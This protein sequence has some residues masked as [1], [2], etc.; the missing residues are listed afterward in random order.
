MLDHKPIKS[1]TLR[2]SYHRP[3]APSSFWGG[4]AVICPLGAADGRVVWKGKQHNLELVPGERP[5]Q[6]LPPDALGSRISMEQRSQGGGRQRS[7]NT[8][9]ANKASGSSW[10]MTGTGATCTPSSA[11]A[12]ARP[13]PGPQPACHSPAASRSGTGHTSGLGVCC[14]EEARWRSRCPEETSRRK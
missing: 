11:C 6:H 5:Q 12:E 13:L 1:K 3:S 14:R 7:G 8:E 2:N 10:G 9:A 4:G